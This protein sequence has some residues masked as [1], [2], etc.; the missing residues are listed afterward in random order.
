MR[1]K[2]YI[3]LAS[4]LFSLVLW[5]SISLSDVYYSNIDVKLTLTDFPKGYTT[6]SSIPDKIRLRVKGQGWKLISF[7]VGPETEFRISS[8]NSIGSHKLSLYNFIESNRWIFSGLEIIKIFPDSIKFYVEKIISKKLPVIPNLDLEFKPGYGLATD[9]SLKPESIIVFGPTSYL[10]P[11]RNL[12]TEIIHL[13]PLD[14]KTETEVEMPAIRGFS[15]N[16]GKVDIGLDVQRIVDRQFDNLTVDVANIPRGKEVILLP[17]KISF[18]VRGGIEILGRLNIDQFH[19]YVK[20]NSVVQDTIGSITPVLEMPENVTL[21]YLKPDRL[22][23]II[24][25]F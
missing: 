10:K 21:Q 14:S 1:K 16:V 20:Y 24:R 12:M 8:G 17:N 15:F 11:M 2:I 25:S 6:G 7:N 13:G 22:R 4:S 9:I 5:G 18:N 23:Y 19:A 3:F